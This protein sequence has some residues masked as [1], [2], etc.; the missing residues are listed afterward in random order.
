M[1]GGDFLILTLCDIFLTCRYVPWIDCAILP[2]QH[3]RDRS[4]GRRGVCMCLTKSINPD[5]TP[6]YQTHICFLRR[7]GCKSEP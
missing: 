6:D 7:R 2:V 3:D 5:Q 4:R 1:N